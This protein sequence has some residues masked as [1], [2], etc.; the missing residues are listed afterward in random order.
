[1]KDLYETLGVAKTADA[2]EIKRAFRKLTQQ[3]HPDKNPGDK[4]AEERFKEVSSAYE[5]LSDADKRKNYD[6]FGDI[7]LTQ[8]FDAERARAY[9]SATRGG[10]GRRG[11]P[12]AP[13]GMPFDESFFSNVGD[14]RGTSFDDLLSQLFG[15]GRVVDPMGARG[16]RPVSQRGHDIEGEITIEFADMLRGAVVPLRIESGSGGAR[17]LD[18]K[19]P[20]GI[21]DGGKLR[22]RGQ[23]GAG[24]PAGDILLTVRVAPH[25]RLKRDGKDLQLDLPVTALE[26]YRG[27]PVDVPTPSGTV[28][29]KLKPGSQ[30]GQTL[31][32]KGKGIAPPGQDPGDL[33]VK[34]DVRL[35]PGGDEA[36]LAALERLQ[37]G[38]DVRA[39]LEL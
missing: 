14:A 30:N 3:F 5:V 13:G 33:L 31:R 35:P 18:V 4:Q 24:D 10:G 11:R 37:A 34:L 20:A 28:T 39:D 7:S 25:P 16:R 21:A 38:A 6:E 9:R 32:L 12:G 36:L 1:V 2:A 23:G 8:G 29:L 19:V 15:G 26:A 17:T 27:G 22:L